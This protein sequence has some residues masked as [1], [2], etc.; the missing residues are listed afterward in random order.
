MVEYIISDGKT[1]DENV[2]TAADGDASA[3]Q[4]IDKGSDTLEEES[5]LIVQSLDDLIIAPSDAVDTKEEKETKEES[6]STKVQGTE[7]GDAKSETVET[8]ISEVVDQFKALKATEDSKQANRRAIS[9]DSYLTS[10][11]TFNDPSLQLPQCL[12]D[13]LIIEM[14]FDRPTR[15]QRYALPIVLQG[16]NLIAQAQTSA[17]KTVCFVIAML[18]RID[19]SQRCLQAICLTPTRE[20]ANQ[21]LSDAVIPL[22][23]YMPDLQVAAALK[24][25][26][27]H[28]IS[29]AHLIVGT[30]GTVSLWLQRRYIELRHVKTFV[31]DEADEMVNVKAQGSATL[32]IKQN[33]PYNCQVLL[34]SATY[35]TEI[36]AYARRIVEHATVITLAPPSQSSAAQDLDRG[37]GGGGGGGEHHSH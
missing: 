5:E 36:L 29:N 24:G 33:L 26:P 6:N 21:I 28:N 12:R 1:V 30:P 37:G 10:D 2:T 16:R 17:G 9:E 23:K 32:Q 35:T 19:T 27:E 8:E 18:N 25:S 15:I 14:K 11:I 4:A 34:F 13:A 7:E 31:L 22:S 3:S 20:L